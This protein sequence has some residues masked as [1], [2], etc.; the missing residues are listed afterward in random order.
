MRFAFL[1]A[2]A[3]VVSI[4]AVARISHGDV[5]EDELKKLHWTWD[6]IDESENGRSG[7]YNPARKV[8]IFGHSMIVLNK[9]ES[10]KFEAKLRNLQPSASPGGTMYV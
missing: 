10:V 1:T 6:V 7:V 3:F 2:V 5:G 8:M 9:L 4:S